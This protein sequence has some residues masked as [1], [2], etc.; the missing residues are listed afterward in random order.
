MSAK[1]MCFYAFPN[2]RYK[3]YKLNI[4]FE[5]FNLAGMRCT[6]A[7]C[8]EGESTPDIISLVSLINLITFYNFQ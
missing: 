5:P 7:R 4:I 2:R 8:M 3:N 6:E 1:I